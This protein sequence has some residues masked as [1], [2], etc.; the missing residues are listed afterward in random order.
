MWF[1]G[2][3]QGYLVFDWVGE[4]RGASESVKG[5]HWVD[6]QGNGARPG[7]TNPPNRWRISLTRS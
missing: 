5:F 6:S 1:S 7:L 2:V 3:E 4:K